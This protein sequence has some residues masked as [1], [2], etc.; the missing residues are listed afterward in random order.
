MYQMSRSQKQS[1]QWEKQEADPYTL[2]SYVSDTIRRGPCCFSCTLP[3]SWNDFVQI[4]TASVQ[5]VCFGRGGLSPSLRMQDV[6]RAKADGDNPPH[7]Y[8]IWFRHGCMSHLRPWEVRR[9]L[10]GLHGKL[11]HLRAFP[12]R[13]PLSL[14]VDKE[15]CHPRVV[16]SHLI[17]RR[18]SRPW[19]EPEA[20]ERRARRPKRLGP[21]WSWWSLMTLLN[22]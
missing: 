11:L 18:R 4:S 8:N 7:G 1:I 17:G 20:R 9:S 3:F 2:G 5:P 22:C 16:G 19:N 6:S 13:P 14:D 12:D 21:W 10:L 15:A